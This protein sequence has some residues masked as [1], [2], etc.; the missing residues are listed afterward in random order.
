MVMLLLTKSERAPVFTEHP[1]KDSRI[2][3]L[4]GTPK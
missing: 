3:M 4:E 2:Y 1:A